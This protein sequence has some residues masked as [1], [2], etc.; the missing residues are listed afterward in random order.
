MTKWFKLM[1]ISLASLLMLVA[2]SSVNADEMEDFVQAFQEAN[3]LRKQS[4][5]LGHEWRDT[6]GLLRDARKKAEAGELEEAQQ[7]VAEANFQAK[8][9]IAQAEREAVLWMGRVPR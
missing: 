8:A 1:R 7:L 3:T 6:A 2:A 5:E 9:A 4:A